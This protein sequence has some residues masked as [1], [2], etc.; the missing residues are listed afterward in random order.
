MTKIIVPLLI[1]KENFKLNN[2]FLAI[3]IANSLLS[4][5]YCL[6][7]IAHYFSPSPVAEL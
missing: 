4:V 3:F 5:A 7:I 6:L 2:I 1:I